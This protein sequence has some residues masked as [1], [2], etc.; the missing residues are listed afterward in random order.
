MHPKTGRCA[1]LFPNGVLFRNEKREMRQKLVEHD[2]IECVLGLGPNLFYNSPMEA[3]VVV[4]RMNKPRKRRNK[5][6]MINAVNEVTRERAQ[7]FLTEVHMER[8][9]GTFRNG[10]D[11]SEFSR[12]VSIDEVRSHKF[13]LSIPLFVKTQSSATDDATESVTIENRIAEWQTSSSAVGAAID[14]LLSVLEECHLG[15]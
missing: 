14:E 5:I 8:I 10:D 6:L 3:C 11:I 1:I 12:L 7:S 13:N 15:R 4:C 9:I 2:V